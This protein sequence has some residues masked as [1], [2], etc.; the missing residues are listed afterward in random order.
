M[1][2]LFNIFRGERK[3]ERQVFICFEN[4]EKK[5]SGRAAHFYLFHFFQF[6]CWSAVK[7]VIFC[8]VCAA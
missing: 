3:R 4:T 6:Y 8:Y 5:V 1:K 2:S 7:T